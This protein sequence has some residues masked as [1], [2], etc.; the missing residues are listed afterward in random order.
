MSNLGYPDTALP[1]HDNVAREDWQAAMEHYLS[2]LFL[3]VSPDAASNHRALES[4]C[5]SLVALNEA[6]AWVGPAPAGASAGPGTLHVYPSI[7]GA[8]DDAGVDSVLARVD[9]A[10][11]AAVRVLLDV[12]MQGTRVVLAVCASDAAAVF[13]LWRRDHG[14]KLQGLEVTDAYAGAFNPVMDTFEA[15][16]PA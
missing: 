7:A 12:A 11:S 13:A 3:V 8:L 9:A 5:C 6:V 2:G 10:D 14:P 15:D 1:A 4:A 16:M